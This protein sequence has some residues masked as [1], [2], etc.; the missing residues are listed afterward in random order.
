[1]TLAGRDLDRRQAN[2]AEPAGEDA[3]RRIGE[4]REQ[5]RQL[6]DEM[7]G[8]PAEQRRADHRR[9]AGEADQ[10]AAETARVEFLFDREQMRDDD[11][12]YRGRRIEDRDKAARQM[13]L[14]PCQQR[15]WRDVVEQREQDQRRRLPVQPRRGNAAER[16]G[17]PQQ[18][19]GDAHS[20][21]DNR[22]WRQALNSNS[23]EEK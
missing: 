16:G 6:S 23:D 12:E 17:E 14:A 11:G 3:R 22:E 7:V 20:R 1:V 10:C 13:G 9:N 18:G 8:E 4:R 15:E 21:R 2:S 19:G 5:R